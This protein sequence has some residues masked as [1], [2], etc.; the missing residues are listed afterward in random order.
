MTATCHFTR[1]Q[2]IWWL[3]T[4]YGWKK[5]APGEFIEASLS[6][7]RY[8]IRIFCANGSRWATFVTPGKVIARLPTD[9]YSEKW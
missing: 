3:T 4:G 6:G 8:Y 7:K 5:R 2:P 9:K 1:D